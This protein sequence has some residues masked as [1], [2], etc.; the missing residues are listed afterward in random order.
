[1]V[2]DGIH[3]ARPVSDGGDDL[4]TGVGEKSSQPLPEQ[5]RVLGDDNPHSE[6][7]LLRVR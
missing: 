2:R 6:P 5:Y 7:A 3:K 1:M 4:A